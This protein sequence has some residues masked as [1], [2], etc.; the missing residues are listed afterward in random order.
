MAKLIQVIETE[1]YRGA[2]TPHDRCRVVR[3]YWSP[4][5][6]LLAEDD[7]SAPRYFCNHPDGAGWLINEG[8]RVKVEK[9][10]Q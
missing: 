9:E 7:P 6:E 5:G 8:D 3:Q 2:G 4:E 10:K 1:I